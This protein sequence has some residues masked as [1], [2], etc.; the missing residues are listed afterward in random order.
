MIEK[1][2]IFAH[3]GLSSV[4]PENTLSSIQAAIDSD[5]EGVEFDVELTRDNQPVVIHQESFLPNSDFD[6]LTLVG[7]QVR[8]SWVREHDLAQIT[9]LDAGKWFKADFEGIKVC[10]LAQVLALDWKGKTALME[11]KDSL[12]WDA[13]EANAYH[14]ELL[15]S[16]KGHIEKF[17]ASG[18][19]IN[20]LSF[21]K[22]V[23]K[24]CAQTLPQTPL[25]LVVSDMQHLEAAFNSNLDH[26]TAV[27]VS[28]TLGLTQPLV[29]KQIQ[30]KGK[31]AYVYEH[32][33]YD[34][35]GDIHQSLEKRRS[36][37]QRLSD[38][39]ADGIIS[40]YAQF[41]RKLAA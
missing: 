37:W 25:V 14:H 35:D 31:L 2:K 6:S 8:R 33:N 22:H 19:D 11:I 17:Q 10:S 36:V 13:A 29:F 21:S 9:K 39:G 5:L 3:R 41:F 15:D 30:G 18:N 38:A 26:L 7:A 12:F 34:H 23:L 32:S 40:N 28:E 4:A 27:T 20:I 24:L 16:V 1:P